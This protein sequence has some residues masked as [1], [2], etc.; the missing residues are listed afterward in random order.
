MI[1]A[2][3]PISSVVIRAARGADLPALA[4]LAELDSA[5]ALTGP[6]L[7]A[8]LGGRIVAARA[9][10]TGGTIADP[11]VASA[12]LLALLELRARPAAAP[13]RLHLPRA[14]KAA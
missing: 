7:V 5:P 11:F 8:E 3:D 4:D 13:G 6:V 14:L 9:T 1:M 12:G 2:S 10:E